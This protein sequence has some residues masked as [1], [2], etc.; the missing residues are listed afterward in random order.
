MVTKEMIKKSMEAKW[1]KRFIVMF[2]ILSAICAPIIGGTVYNGESFADM[3]KCLVV[4]LLPLLFA[5]L[6]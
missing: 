6:Y 1:R 2:V 5:L 4:P 3:I